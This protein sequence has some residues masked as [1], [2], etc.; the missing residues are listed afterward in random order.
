MALRIATKHLRRAGIPSGSEEPLPKAL[1][2]QVQDPRLAGLY[3][4]LDH[5]SLACIMVYFP[6]DQTPY[7]CI[8]SIASDDGPNGAWTSLVETHLHLL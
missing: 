1:V 2:S 8:V 5:H 3:V 7:L 6:A 4:M